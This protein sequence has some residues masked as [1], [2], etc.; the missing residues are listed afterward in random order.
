M[1][2]LYLGDGLFA[3]YDGFQFRLRA[4]RAE[5]DHEVFLEPMVYR[6]FAKFADRM[7]R[8]ETRFVIRNKLNGQLLTNDLGR[9]FWTTNVVSALTYKSEYEANIA[10]EVFFRMFPREE[11]EVI[12][13]NY[14]APREMIIEIQ[15]REK[16]T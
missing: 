12:K 7:V 13:V 1:N 15:E 9:P 14:T 16:T 4:P 6:V 2:E 8:G 3:S 5:G 11:P 10:M